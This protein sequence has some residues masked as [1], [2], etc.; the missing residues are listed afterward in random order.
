MKVEG[1]LEKARAAHVVAMEEHRNRL[2]VLK[3]EEQTLWMVEHGNLDDFLPSWEREQGVV[4]SP[5][6]PEV[7]AVRDFEHMWHER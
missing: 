4:L 2:D 6:A 1:F 7:V 5:L 3:F